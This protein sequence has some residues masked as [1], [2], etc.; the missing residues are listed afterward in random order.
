LQLVVDTKETQGNAAYPCVLIVEAN[1][2]MPEL[3]DTTL[4][5]PEGQAIAFVGEQE[6]KEFT[7]ALQI[8]ADNL[9]KEPDNRTIRIGREYD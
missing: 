3:A 8:L 1:Q 4:K 7:E 6:F 9:R 5:S 2:P